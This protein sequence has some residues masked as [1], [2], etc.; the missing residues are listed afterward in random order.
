MWL[1]VI[2]GTGVL[3]GVI[4]E[5]KSTT[6]MPVEWLGAQANKLTA[7]IIVMNAKRI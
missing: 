5:A 7:K 6:G 4:E 3:D 1:V 2:S